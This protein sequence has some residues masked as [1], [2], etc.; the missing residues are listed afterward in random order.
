M[1]EVDA[2]GMAVEVEPSSQYSITF[3]CHVTA[4]DGQ[5]D[6]MASDMEGCMNSSVQKELHSLRFIDSC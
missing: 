2:G 1:S 5:S 6:Q 3:C 4:A